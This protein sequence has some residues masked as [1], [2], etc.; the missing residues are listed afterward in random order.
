M[1]WIYVFNMQRLLRIEDQRAHYSLDHREWCILA[2]CLKGVQV[3]E[4][5]KGIF[6][7]TLYPYCGTLTS[8]GRSCFQ[9]PSQEKTF[10]LHGTFK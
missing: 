7:N 4:R 9:L 5:I 1:Y 8:C 3:V 2:V 6:I 10:T